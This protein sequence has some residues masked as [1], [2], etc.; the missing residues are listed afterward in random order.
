MASERWICPGVLP[1]GTQA[2]PANRETSRQR[3]PA[4]NGLLLEILPRRHLRKSSLR[5]L[6]S[7]SPERLSGSKPGLPTTPAHPPA[8]FNWKNAAYRLGLASDVL[9]SWL[10]DPTGSVTSTTSSHRRLVRVP[11]ELPPDQQ[12]GHIHPSQTNPHSPPA[13]P[14]RC[15]YHGRFPITQFKGSADENPQLLPPVPPSGNT[16]RNLH[17]RRI[18]SASNCLARTLPSVIEHSTPALTGPPD[19]LG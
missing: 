14:R 12:Y 9:W 17:C 6:R 8:R 2:T 18:P 3:I 10:P 16:G 15:Q 7:D 13:P 1:S 19:Q 5:R 11:P 4:Q